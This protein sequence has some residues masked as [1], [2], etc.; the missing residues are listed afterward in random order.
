MLNPKVE[1]LID[2]YD[3]ISECTKCSLCTNGSRKAFDRNIV[4]H[5]IDNVK[6]VFCGMSPAY[7]ESMAGI[8]FVGFSEL[9]GSRCGW[10]KRLGQC[11][12]WFL[13]LD[14]SY[15]NTEQKCPFTPTDPCD[16]IT[17]EKYVERL[18]TVP[19]AMIYNKESEIDPRTAGQLFNMIL[20]QTPFVRSTVADYWYDKKEF[21]DN[22]IQLPIPNCA[23]INAV[24]CRAIVNT[25]GKN[26]NTDPL[27]E[28]REICS[29]Y[30]KE[31]IEI[32]EPK[33]IIAL[34]K[35]AILATTDIPAS[36]NI[37]EIIGQSVGYRYD[38]SIPVFSLYH[39]SFYLHMLS[40]TKP[41]KKD[42][43]IQKVEDMKKRDISILIDIHKNLCKN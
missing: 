35:E 8:P 13:H 20:S 7:C 34:G 28:E 29:T 23:I 37:S 41:E 32:L 39:P 33:V 43:A 24:Q 19:P 9:L 16:H 2:L 30:V 27:A 21:I 42:E 14:E 25:N 4:M 38:L 36:K 17:H 6:A 15:K 11:Y 18:K 31:F 40:N 22:T 12:K 10:C 26:E 5:D 1:K 3:R